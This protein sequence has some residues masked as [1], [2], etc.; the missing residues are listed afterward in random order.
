MRQKLSVSRRSLT[1]Q[2]LQEMK[3]RRLKVKKVIRMGNLCIPHVCLSM[4]KNLQTEQI[5]SPTW[6]CCYYQGHF[7]FC[8]VINNQ[9]FL[10]KKLEILHT[11]DSDRPGFITSSTTGS[12]QK[13]RFCVK[14]FCSANLIMGLNDTVVGKRE[15]EKEP[16]ETQ[17]FTEHD[18]YYP[19]AGESEG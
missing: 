1:L 8:F 6:S 10:Y 16:K 9:E 5:I 3:L 18:Y 19:R 12:S 2:E 11:S 7:P 17:K 14:Q 15:R 13:N 4:L